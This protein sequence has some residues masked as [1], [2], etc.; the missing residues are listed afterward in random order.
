M[1]RRD[2]RLGRGGPPRA[3]IIRLGRRGVAA[4]AAVTPRKGAK[5]LR[6]CRVFFASERIRCAK[7]QACA[8]RRRASGGDLAAAL[9]A[10]PLDP[11]WHLVR[12]VVDQAVSRAAAKSAVAEVISSR[13]K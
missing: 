10:G 8:R 1:R 12:H 13:E 4:V 9:D 2:G 5:L 11:Q 3:E 6:I 7:W